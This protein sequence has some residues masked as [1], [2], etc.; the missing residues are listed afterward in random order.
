MMMLTKEKIRNTLPRAFY[1]LKFFI[2]YNDISYFS[3]C[4]YLAENDKNKLTWSHRGNQNPNI[5]ILILDIDGKGVGMGPLLQRVLRGLFF[6]EF[7]GFVPVVRFIDTY[8]KES[9]TFLNTDNV[10]EYYFVQPEDIDVNTAEISSRVFSCGIS[11]INTVSNFLGF[12][13]MYEV[14]EKYLDEM[15]R[16]SRKLKLNST[17]YNYIKK[18]I[19]SIYPKGE[20]KKT[21]GV[22]VRGTDFLLKWE[23][24]PVPIRPEEYFQI[25]DDVLTD[26]GY[27][28]VFLATD[29]LNIL[30]KFQEKYGEVLLFYADV[31]R[32]TNMENISM[33]STGRQ[34]EHYLNGVEVLR[35]IYTL[36][37][38][39]G[40]IAGYSHVS[41]SAR[42]LR[43]GMEKPFDYEKVLFKGI[44]HR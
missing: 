40:L 5:N 19:K 22:H 24:H 15:G 16:I 20:I 13:G 32:G 7:Y 27:E 25:I 9:D 3:K 37:W 36:A 41:I 10:F 14:S 42:I 44:Y 21:L 30:K 11:Q 4:N 31:H 17:T 2:H 23:G 29:D 28:Y 6:A 18:S 34:H 12:K 35:D 38:S 43:R 1:L 39:D 33:V 8:Y 26:Y